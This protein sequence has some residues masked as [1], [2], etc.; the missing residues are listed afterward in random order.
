MNK[1]KSGK[2]HQEFVYEVDV[3]LE[4]AVPRLISPHAHVRHVT[5]EVARNQSIHVRPVVS[6]FATTIVSVC[7]W[8]LFRRVVQGTIGVREQLCSR[9]LVLLLAHPRNIPTSQLINCRSRI[10]RSMTSHFGA[11]F[12]GHAWIS[13]GRQAGGSLHGW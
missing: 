2:S 13:T 1:Y 12:E 6:G 7:M 4:S 9:P 10:Y 11:I 5:I 3:M 8:L